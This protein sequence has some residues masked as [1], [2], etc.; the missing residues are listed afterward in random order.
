MQHIHLTHYL[1]VCS[2]LL[3]VLVI[4]SQ[5]ASFTVQ[6]YIVIYLS[7]IQEIERRIK[8]ET[9]LIRESRSNKMDLRYVNLVV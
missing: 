4:Y 3:N 6:E 8:F 7:V 2:Y 1:Q 9:E 5:S